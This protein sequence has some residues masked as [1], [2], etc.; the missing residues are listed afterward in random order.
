M[1]WRPSQRRG[2]LSGRF[3]DSDAGSIT[4]EFAAVM[5]AILLVLAFCLGAVHVVAQ[6][7]RLTDAA[8]DGA[9][10]LARGDSAALASA[11]V[12]QSVG[13]VALAQSRNG[14]FVCVSLSAPAA[15]GPAAAIGI[16]VS[17]RGCALMG[18]L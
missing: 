15:F 3:A 17:A 16:T 9:R 10:S 13:S 8:A 7:V 2:A 18:G 12:S 6:Q 14:D 5:P 1:P 4:A 11:R